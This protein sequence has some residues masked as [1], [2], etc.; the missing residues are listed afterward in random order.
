MTLMMVAVLSVGMTACGSD[1]DDDNK[2]GNDGFDFPKDKLY[3]TWQISEVKLSE[4]AKDYVAWPYDETTISFKSDGTF[5]GAGYFGSGT[6]TYIVKGKTI[7]T[8]VQNNVYMTYNVLN[9]DGTT[10]ELKATQA[11]TG[12]TLWVKCVRK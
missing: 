3:G 5:S 9:L 10:A 11:T 4:S 8:Y 2:G 1:G 6:G 12:N 7:T